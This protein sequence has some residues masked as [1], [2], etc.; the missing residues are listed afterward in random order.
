MPTYKRTCICYQN[1]STCMS[2]CNENIIFLYLLHL[3]QY[4]FTVWLFQTQED[5]RPRPGA[6]GYRGEKQRHS[7]PAKS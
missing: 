6:Q 7:D 3:F 2:K 5:T 4:F 1:L